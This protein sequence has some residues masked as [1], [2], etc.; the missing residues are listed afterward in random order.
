MGGQV[1]VGLGVDVGEAPLVVAGHEGLGHGIQDLGMVTRE[2]ILPKENGESVARGIDPDLDRAAVSG[3]GDLVGHCGL[4]GIGPVQRPSQG[5]VRQRGTIPDDSAD[6]IGGRRSGKAG[7]DAFGLAI[8]IG[9]SPIWVQGEDAF[10]NAIE[11]IQRLSG[12]EQPG[13]PLR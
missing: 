12:V 2:G 9:E 3:I 13:E 7:E 10:A 8:Q 4:V 11:Q 1:A 6:E 5:R